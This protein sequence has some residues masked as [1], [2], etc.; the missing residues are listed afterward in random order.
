MT[1]NPPAK[2]E[3]KILSFFKEL[4]NEFKSFLW[5]I[6]IYSSGQEYLQSIGICS[7]ADCK[8]VDANTLQRI[9]GIGPKKAARILGMAEFKQPPAEMANVQS[10]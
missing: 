10:N 2:P 8:K 7:F 3:G 9:R 4:D 1:K 5:N 6:G